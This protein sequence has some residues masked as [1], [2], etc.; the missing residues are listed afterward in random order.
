VVVGRGG[1]AAPPLGMLREQNL[2]EASWAAVPDGSYVDGYGPDY[3]QYFEFD[4]LG[5]TLPV[6][7]VPL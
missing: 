7:H 5:A 6:D 3:A 1:V 2:D 4:R